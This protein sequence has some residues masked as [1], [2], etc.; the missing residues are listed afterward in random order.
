MLIQG[1][2]AGLFDLD[3]AIDEA[4]TS[5]RRSGTDIIISY[6]TPRI[7]KRLKD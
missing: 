4:F 6:F 5:L 3:T 1:A 2:K 7:L